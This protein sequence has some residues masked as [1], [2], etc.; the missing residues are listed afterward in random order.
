MY[1]TRADVFSFAVLLV[2][3]FNSEA[4][5]VTLQSG[6]IMF[7]V[8]SGALRPSLPPCLPASVC[9]A[10]LGL[11]GLPVR[12]AVLSCAWMRA[13]E[14]CVFRMLWMR[15]CVYVLISLHEFVPCVGNLEKL[16]Y[17]HV[18]HRCTGTRIHRADVAF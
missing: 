8:T 11:H 1:A 3:V 4:P 16:L 14:P 9:T 6:E 18:R 12:R 15:G 10:P 2:A 17:V 5:Y 13:C 7:G